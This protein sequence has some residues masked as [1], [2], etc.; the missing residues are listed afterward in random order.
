MGLQKINGSKCL[1]ESNYRP[2][3]KINVY[4]NGDNYCAARQFTI[5]KILENTKEPEAMQGLC[6]MLTTQLKENRQF[7]DERNYRDAPSE[8]VHYLLTP[9]GGTRVDSINALKPDHDYVAC[10]KNKL[11]P[12]DYEQIGKMNNKPIRR[13]IHTTW[14][15]L[16]QN[17]DR[18]EPLMAPK[19]ILHYQKFARHYKHNISELKAHYGDSKERKVIYIYGNGDPISSTRILLSGRLTQHDRE[20]F[21]LVLNYI[22]DKV[23]RTLAGT[24][25]A[26]IMAARRI[27][28]LQG[29]RVRNQSQIK[30]GESYVVCGAQP[31]KRVPYG[32]FEDIQ[33]AWKSSFKPTRTND[34]RIVMHEEPTSAP[35]LRPKSTKPTIILPKLPKKKIFYSEKFLQSLSRSNSPVPN[36]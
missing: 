25:S 33:P 17:K 34:G 32:Q 24:R 8:A 31:L 9:Y 11:I 13:N 21:Q 18:A 27:Y 4:V 1:N 20:G 12:I 16:R 5:P 22:S 30:D 10:Y 26:G 35:E 28:N 14:S 7:R 19:P 2:A 23:G 29:K 36:A 6:S 15:K 3:K